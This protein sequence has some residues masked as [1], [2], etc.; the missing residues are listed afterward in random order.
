MRRAQGYAT[1]TEP[2]K[3]LVEMDTCQCGHCQRLTHV[4]PKQDPAE[5]GGLCKCCMRLIC[6]PC[7]DKGTCDVFEK[8]LERAEASYHARRSYGLG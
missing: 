1:I 7:V 6:G 2:G 5:L 4:K 3:R 8:K